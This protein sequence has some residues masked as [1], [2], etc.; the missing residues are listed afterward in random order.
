MQFNEIT[1]KLPNFY[2][3][4]KVSATGGLE[5]VVSSSSSSHDA[6]N[7]KLSECIITSF[8]FMT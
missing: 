8:L 6:L 4:Y 5:A 1:V 2:K 7:Q 3:V